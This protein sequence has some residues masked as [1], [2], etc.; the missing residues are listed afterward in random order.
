MTTNRDVNLVATIPDSTPVAPIPDSTPVAQKPDE[1]SIVTPPPVEPPVLTSPPVDPAVVT[2]PPVDPPVVTPQ[3]V[4]A[5]IVTTRPRKTSE[6]DAD[7]W[8]LLVSALVLV[9]GAALAWQKI[10]PKPPRVADPFSSSPAPLIAVTAHVESSITSAKVEGT[11][12]SGPTV[13]VA[14][15]VDSGV[16]DMTFL[17]SGVADVTFPEGV[18]R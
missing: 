15:S 5:P 6:R 8:G 4:D 1:A 13:V 10:R 17:D 18:P 14:A 16:A 7:V 11:V 12:P 2:L 9:G 3:P